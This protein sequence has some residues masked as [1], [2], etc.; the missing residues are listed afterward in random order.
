MRFWRR[1]EKPPALTGVSDFCP[2]CGERATSMTAA[3]YVGAL[4]RLQNP[5]KS[6]CR[7]GHEWVWQD[8][9]DTPA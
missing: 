9:K 2:V 5:G 1:R 6:R 4:G 3:L 7:K 8:R